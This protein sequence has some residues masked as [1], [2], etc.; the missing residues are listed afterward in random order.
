VGYKGGSEFGVLST[1]W[2]L[3]RADG[4]TFFYSVGFKNPDG[5]VDPMVAIVPIV[6]GRDLLETT[7]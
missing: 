6:V 7:P 4:R 1:T 2:L 5:P 3:D